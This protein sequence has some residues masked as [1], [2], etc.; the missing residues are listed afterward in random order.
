MTSSTSLQI[1]LLPLLMLMLMLVL[2]LVLMVMLAR[3]KIIAF[4]SIFRC[5]SVLQNVGQ[6]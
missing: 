4:L 1:I 2:V 6:R 5:Y 3:S